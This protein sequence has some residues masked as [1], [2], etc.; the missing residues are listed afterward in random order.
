MRGKELD[1]FVLFFLASIGILYANLTKD[2]YIGKAA[3]AGAIYILPS[4]IYL[5]LRKK[6]NW[7]KITV[8]TL[9]FGGLFGFLFEFIQ[10]FN[11]SYSV[12]SMI[13]PFKVFGVLPLDNVA[14]HI[15]MALLTVTFYEHFIEREINHHISKHLKYAL[16]PS[17]FAIGVVILLYFFDPSAL[18]TKYPYFYMGIA[19][20]LPPIFLGITQP[21]FVKNMVETAFYFFFFYL[22]IELVAV[23]NAWWIYRGNNYIGW[24]TVFG[25]TF[26]FEE[27]FFWMLFYSASLVSYYELFVDNHSKLKRHRKKK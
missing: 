5:G 27:L 9:L 11:H 3:I 23:K 8:S 22:A 21:R 12:V 17:I 26:P 7:A 25:I 18:Q 13:V 19:A 6:K 24:V 10:E 14:G 1:I 20:I 16:L 2:L 4:V 15:M